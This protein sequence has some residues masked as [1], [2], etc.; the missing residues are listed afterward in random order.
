MYDD[1]L[2]HTQHK[3]LQGSRIP[4]DTVDHR[5]G[6][7]FIIKSHGQILGFLVN[8]IAQSRHDSVAAHPQQIPSES[9][10]GILQ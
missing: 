5:T 6:G 9:A 1:F 3:V 10:N 8:V 4:A 7:G 2:G